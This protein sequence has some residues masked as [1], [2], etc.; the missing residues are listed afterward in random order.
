M[1]PALFAAMRAAE[2]VWLEVSFAVR[3]EFLLRD[4][5]YFLKDPA[6]LGQRLDRLVEL[7]GKEQVARWRALVDAGSWEELVDSLLADHYD[8]A[9]RKAA[10]RDFARRGEGVKVGLE[11]LTT[12]ALAEAARGLLTV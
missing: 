8:P 5:D 11:R 12:E 2:P 9:Y 7:H 3:V 10:Q 4:Y 1:P 6:W